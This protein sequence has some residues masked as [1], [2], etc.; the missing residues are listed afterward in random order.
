MAAETKESDQKKQELNIEIVSDNICPWC[1]VGKRNLETA[2]S[3]LDKNK[4]NINIKWSAFELDPNLPKYESVDKKARYKKKFGDGV[5]NL[6][7]RMNNVGSNC[8]PP[9]NFKWNGNIGNTFNSH[10][11]VLFGQESN[12]MNET[13]EMIMHYYFELNKDI[14]NINVLTEIGQK[15]GLKVCCF[16]LFSIYIYCK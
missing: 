10:R 7:K 3:K 2:L 14:S 12:K 11:L 13:V 15:V 1:F 9:I 5:E 8:N 6:L 16:Y 4:V